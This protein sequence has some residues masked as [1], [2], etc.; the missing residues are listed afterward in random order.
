M[1][2]N[3]SFSVALPLSRGMWLKRESAWGTWGEEKTK[4]TLPQRGRLSSHLCS[5]YPSQAPVCWSLQTFPSLQ[6]I[7]IVSVRE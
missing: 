4:G 7:V 3:F 6:N 2:I 5:F 1:H